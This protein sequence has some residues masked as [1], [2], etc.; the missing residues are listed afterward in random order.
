MLIEQDKVLVERFTR[1]GN[2]WLLT[3][4]KSLD[5]SL[6]L[7]SIGCEIALREIYAL[8]EFPGKAAAGL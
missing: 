5:D 7:A 6:P 4:F 2:E 3:E 8:I 1:Q